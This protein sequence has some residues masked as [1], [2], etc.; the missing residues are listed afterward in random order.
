MK[1]I[2][3]TM[4]LVLTGMMAMAQTSVWNGGKALWTHGAGTESDPYL[5]ESADQL[6]GLAYIVNKGYNTAGMHFRLTTDI[7][8]NGSED[9]PWLPIGLG[10]RWFSEDGCKRIIYNGWL[11]DGEAFPY[12]RGHFD[13]GNHCIFN[14]YVEGESNAGLF[15]AARS[16]SYMD[17]IVIENV[18]VVGGTI[19]GSTCGGIIGNGRSTK[20]VV[21]HCWNG[22]AITGSGYVGGIVGDGATQVMNCYNIGDVAGNKVGGIVG[23]D[24]RLIEECYNS[25]TIEGDESGAAGGI[26]GYGVGNGLTINNCYNTGTVSAMGGE[27]GNYPVAGGLV[28]VG[29]NTTITNSYNVGEV[30]CTNH[31]GCLIGTTVGDLAVE[32]THYLNTCDQSE[33]GESQSE[34]MMRS[35]AFVGLLNHQDPEPVFAFDANNFNDGFPVFAKNILSVEAMVSP[36]ESGEI[37]GAGVYPFGSVATVTVTPKTDYQFRYWSK[38]GE[39]VSED[40]SYSFFVSEDCRLMAQLSGNGV[41]EEVAAGL[42]IYPNPTQ[43]QFT[44]EGTGRMTVIN[45]LGQT[46]LTRDVEGQTIVELPKG[47]YFVKLDGITQKVLVE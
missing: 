15:G 26:V 12:F 25:G 5:I 14:I 31:L 4:M 1:K 21:S 33:A 6:A 45:L 10:N 7:D 41:D 13:G 42:K 18:F 19:S 36:A 2:Y 24:P 11:Y 8:L 37:T 47:L 29:R 20:L 32:N 16:D 44:V 17:T 9:L 30:S 35:Q 40:L 23:S 39:V 34:S 27:E 22:A 46:I 28:G 43:S 38:N 3:I